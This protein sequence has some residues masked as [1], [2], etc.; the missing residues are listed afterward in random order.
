MSDIV[1]R[2][3]PSKVGLGLSRVGPLLEDYPGSGLLVAVLARTSSC[4]T[5]WP[6]LPQVLAFAFTPS[7]HVQPLAW[8][9]D[10]SA[11]TSPRVSGTLPSSARQSA[12]RW[13]HGKIAG[14]PTDQRR[15]ARF[16]QR[17]AR[18]DGLHHR[19][20]NRCGSRPSPNDWPGVVTT[21]IGEAAPSRCLTFSSIRK[22]PFLFE[23][24][25]RDGSALDG[26][27]HRAPL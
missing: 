13:A 20:S 21:L 15:P 17:R 4:A 27:D 26:E 5:A 10:G 16:R 23:G 8:C 3:R 6:W 1:A 2:P 11:R 12:K 22:G 25:S 18:Q 9:R 24:S 14:L 7:V 19:Q